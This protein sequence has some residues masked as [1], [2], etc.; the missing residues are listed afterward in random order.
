VGHDEEDYSDYS[1][2]INTSI[3]GLTLIMGFTFTAITLLLT[4]LDNPSSLGS[5]LMLLLLVIIFYLDAFIVEHLSVETLYYCK[6]VPPRTQK[7]AVRTALI[8]LSSALFGLA[9]PFMFLLFDLA[10]LS[11][12]TGIIWFSGLLAQLVIIFKPL[13][14]YRRKNVS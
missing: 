9:V 10:Y 4:R 1:R 14:E 6:K 2:H 7:I 3:N 13:Q 5:Q 8:V 11:V 12:V